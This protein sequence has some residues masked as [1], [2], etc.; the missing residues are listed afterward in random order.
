MIKERFE[1]YQGKRRQ[2]EEEKIKKATEKAKAEAERIEKKATLLEA[3]V[4]EKMR[5]AKAKIRIA[6]ATGKSY[7]A[8]ISKTERTRRVIS[9]IGKGI[10]AADRAF[11]KAVGINKPKRKTAPKRKTTA[12]K[13]YTKKV[14]GGTLISR[15]KI[16]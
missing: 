9:G 16:N 15:K 2:R 12:K 7:K 14:K 3:K 6:K 13:V 4:T 11:D 10:S 5:V 1:S 8:S